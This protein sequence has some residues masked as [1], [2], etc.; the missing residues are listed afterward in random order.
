MRVKS[1]IKVKP[2]TVQV[3]DLPSLKVAV[4]MITLAY[5]ELMLGD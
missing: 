1:A 4:D 2:T 3:L 5:E